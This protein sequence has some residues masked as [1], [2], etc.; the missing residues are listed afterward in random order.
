MTLT[1]RYIL[2]LVLIAVTVSISAWTIQDLLSTQR[3]D[4][5]IINRAGQQ[6]MLSQRISLAVTR[7]SQCDT[8]DSLP[9]DTLAIALKRFSENHTYLVNQP[10]MPARLHAM[11]FS[12]GGLDAQSQAY[13][14]AGYRLLNN[15]QCFAVPEIFAQAYSDQLL[16]KLDEAVDIFEQSARERVA[17]IETIEFYLW[18]IT[19]LMLLGEALLIFRPM[20]QK[21][22]R[23]IARLKVAKEEAEAASKA[24]SSFL[25]NMSHELRTPMN[26]MFGMIELAR[27]NPGKANAYLKKALAAGNQLL[28]LINDILDLSKIEADKLVISNEHFNLLEMLDDLATLYSIS[29][30]RKNLAFN[31]QRSSN[32][33][34]T[35]IGD[36]KRMSQVLHN[37]LSNAVKFTPKG[38]VTLEVALVQHGQRDW[39]SFRVTDTGVGILPEHAESIFNDFEQ[40]NQ[41]TTKLFGGTGLGLSIA[42][43]L[44]TLMDGKLSFDSAEQQG[45]EFRFLLPVN[46]PLAQ[47]GDLLPAV[48]LKAAVV[49]DLQTSREYLSHI[50]SEMGVET[51]TFSSAQDFLDCE[52]KFD[53]ALIDL[54]MPE[55]DGV[56]LIRKV[57]ARGQV[58]PP[59]LIVVSA[60]LEHIDAEP[61]ILDAI[62]RM[63]AK[64]V[65]RNAIKSDILALQSLKASGEEPQS[66]TAGNTTVEVLVAED[67][68]I[69]AEVIRSMLES[70]G[71]EVTVAEN[72]QLAIDALH[73]VEFDLIFMD[74]QMPT[75]DGLEATSIIR[76]TLGMT[77]IPIIA[78]TANA[79]AEDR[80]RCLAA[81]MNDFLTKPVN[82]DKVISIV[83]R[84]TAG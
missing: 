20:V 16:I 29:C 19:L 3:K 55:I 23:T 49:D 83:R 37:L 7:L 9:R 76:N 30:Q 40:G 57:L 15:G 60:V 18:V 27:E 8:P 26:G 61:R 39:L 68:E 11:Y 17:E 50:L 4:A 51:L 70:A 44:A 78:L 59:Y 38:S 63:Y 21:I 82:R 34:T 74:V 42:K 79:F 32:L 13:L 1:A 69:N 46:I 65:D 22:N 58:P 14:Q 71:C 64:P 33:P 10:N 73:G 43:R 56:T 53:V 6:R 66:S 45:S 35:V 81:G 77:D 62:W 67:N 54:S 24:K 48:S 25:A 28:T 80:E 75:M 52:K 72:G 2:A 5:E 84:Y 12:D 41:S 36:P 47:P 31:Y